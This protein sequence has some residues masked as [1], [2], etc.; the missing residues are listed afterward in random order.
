ML[1]KIINNEYYILSSLKLPLQYRCI[2]YLSTAALLQRT[3]PQDKIELCCG[4]ALSAVV[5]AYRRQFGHLDY[6]S[7]FIHFNHL[8]VIFC[9]VLHNIC[10]WQK[11]LQMRGK[12]YTFVTSTHA[13]LPIIDVAKQHQKKVNQ[14]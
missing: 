6:E 8:I 12:N 3:A 4:T 9:M 7:T 13:F 10:N 11:I 2:D 14:K 1:V 5:G